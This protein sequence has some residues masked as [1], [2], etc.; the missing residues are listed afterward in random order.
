[1]GANVAEATVVGVPEKAAPLV[2]IVGPGEANSAFTVSRLFG[3]QLAQS[4]AM[5]TAGYLSSVTITPE[6]YQVVSPG[7][8]DVMNTSRPTGVAPELH[9]EQAF[10]SGFNEVTAPAVAVNLTMTIWRS[11]AGQAAPESLDLTTG[12]SMV[13][14]AT[15]NEPIRIKHDYVVALP[16][17]ALLPAGQYV[18]AFDFDTPDHNLL[19]IRLSGRESGRNTSYNHFYETTCQYK[20]AEDA[21]PSGR[22]YVGLGDSTA[23]RPLTAESTVG[24]GTR[25]LVTEAKVIACGGRGTFNT[26][27]N[28]GDIALTL[29]G[30]PASNPPA[31]YSVSR[32]AYL[33]RLAYAGLACDPFAANLATLALPNG[34]GPEARAAAACIQQDWMSRAGTPKP[35]LTMHLSP[36]YP[37]DWSA[38]IPRAVAAG[39]RLFGQYGTAGH[40]YEVF[41]SADAAW[42]CAEGSRLVDG[43]PNTAAAAPMV[44]ALATGSGCP[45]TNYSPGSGYPTN[46]GPN[47]LTYFTWSL[48]TDPNHDG[49]IDDPDSA[50][51]HVRFM[52]HEFVHTAQLERARFPLGRMQMPGVWFGEGMA[53]FLSYW[54]GSLSVGPADIR[55]YA[56]SN[57]R[58]DMTKSGVKH[59]SIASVDTDANG[60]LKYSTGFFAYEYLVAHFGIPATFDWISRWSASSCA[61]AFNGCW[62]DTAP[63][64]FGMSADLLMAR[65]DA[66][67]N[68]QLDVAPNVTTAKVPSTAATQTGTHLPNSRPQGR[69]H[70]GQTSAV[71]GTQWVC[72]K[73][74]SAWV[75][76]AGLK[77]KPVGACVNGNFAYSNGSVWVCQKGSTSSPGRWV[78]S[79][80]Y[81]VPGS[82]A[83]PKSLCGPGNHVGAGGITWLCRTVGG[84]W[85]W[86]ST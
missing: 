13:A 8:W 4:F 74:G 5:P 67:V 25:Y 16:V 56:L 53:Q 1:V 80:R 20:P 81:G 15:S 22:A 9:N 46:V 45:G 18:V 32:N 70:S 60:E 78:K 66:Y 79:T 82:S 52:S 62:R 43:R 76:G 3:P 77:S 23:A 59:V 49:P 75:W 21:Y 14:R 42:S 38:P 35:Q 71:G 68:A 24:F 41:A 65:L 58:R 30:W 63:E 33:P 29:S 34:A 50:R 31:K 69:C 61:T 64:L 11:D 51:G 12:Y 54:A 19:L 47:G 2:Q 84:R 27:T 10:V 73:A 28:Q 57:L 55:A 7:Y 6:E 44:W 72:G 83:A 40:T 17:A 86:V 36:N 39:D 85:R 26:P 37:A 48:I